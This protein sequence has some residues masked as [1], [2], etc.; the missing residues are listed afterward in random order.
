MIL[1]AIVALIAFRQ[2]LSP[3]RAIPSRI[4]MDYSFPFPLSIDV[5]ACPDVPR[6]F[7]AP[8]DALPDEAWGERRTAWAKSYGG[9]DRLPRPLEPLEGEDQAMDQLC[10]FRFTYHG[11]R[12]TAFRVYER[13][14]RPLRFRAPLGPPP[15]RAPARLLLRKEQR[16]YWR[17]VRGEARVEG[18]LA[19][20]PAGLHR[21]VAQDRLAVT[22]EARFAYDAEGRLC[23]RWDRAAYPEAIPPWIPRRWRAR[24]LV[25]GSAKLYRYSH[26]SSSTVRAEYSG[27]WLLDSILLIKDTEEPTGKSSLLLKYNRDL[28][29]T[30]AWL[31]LT[32]LKDRER[33]MAYYGRDGGC[34]EPLLSGDFSKWI[35]YAGAPGGNVAAKAWF[36]DVRITDAV[37]YDSEGRV[38]A[39]EDRGYAV[40][41][42]QVADDGRWRA[43]ARYG[44]DGHLIRASDAIEVLNIDGK[45]RLWAACRFNHR[46]LLQR[47]QALI[48]VP[49]HRP[50]VDEAYR[51]LWYR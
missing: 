42:E 6:V 27:A 18:W 37:S 33:G 40:K 17:V 39:D 14:D 20:L 51:M 29:F 46:R 50:P 3:P 34:S 26:S 8:R 32:D 41:R 9:L 4:Q 5:R 35:Q 2:L 31:N 43:T 7:E 36:Y 10:C 21:I 13:A 44:L 48:L 16:E 47:I 25:R 24:P 19:A 12:L 38:V 45:D 49:S 22:Y 30:E 15:G 1:F 23:A 28:Q 11:T